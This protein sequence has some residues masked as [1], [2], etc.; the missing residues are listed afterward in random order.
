MTSLSTPSPEPTFIKYLIEEVKSCD[1]CPHSQ[2][3]RAIGT[4]VTWVA[5][6]YPKKERRFVGM[7]PFGDVRINH[8][9]TWCPLP[10]KL[11]VKG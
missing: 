10:D 11:G 3:L 5:C 4:D 7:I 8:I 6:F 2:K 1:D 9:P